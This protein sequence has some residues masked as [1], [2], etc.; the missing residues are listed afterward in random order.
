[1]ATTRAYRFCTVLI[2]S[3]IATCTI[4]KVRSRGLLPTSLATSPLVATFQSVMTSASAT[5]VAATMPA[6]KADGR[7][8]DNDFIRC[9]LGLTRVRPFNV[10]GCVS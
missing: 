3:D 4:A 7:T 1:V 2:A 5:G 8:F 10:T 6:S 9:S